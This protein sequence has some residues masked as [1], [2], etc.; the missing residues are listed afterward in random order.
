MDTGFRSGADQQGDRERFIRIIGFLVGLYLGIWLIGIHITLPVGTF[1]Y[2]YRYGKAG[3]I[4]SSVISL[5]FLALI[6]GVYDRIVG[7]NW[8]DPLLFQLFGLD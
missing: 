1:F 2:L 7:T 5:V 4:V 8:G 6:V 3:L